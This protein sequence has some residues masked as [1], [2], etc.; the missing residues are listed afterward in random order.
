M[1]A[2]E[3]AAANV[4]AW[5]ALIPSE[6]LTPFETLKSYAGKLSQL[7]EFCHDSE[8]ISPLKTTTATIVRYV[9]W[10]GERGH[11]GAK[12]LHPYYLSTISEFFELHNIDPIAKDSM[13]IT[14]AR[15]GMSLCESRCLP[16]SLTL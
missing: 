8:N 13:H 12:S 7:A 9:A 1:V 16:M 11:I 2:V 15:R 5:G 10:I 14:A 4:T 3:G 6:L